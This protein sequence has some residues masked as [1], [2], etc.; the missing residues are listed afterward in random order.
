LTTLYVVATPI[1][2]LGD[3]SQR[4]IETLKQVRRVL[5]EDT[6]RT[7]GL[8]SHL[9]ISGKP[10]QRLDAHATPAE[11]EAVARAIAGGESAA[12]VTDAGAPGVSDPG[13]G[14]MRAALAAGVKLVPIPGPSAVTTAISLCDFVEGPFAFLGFLP[15]QGAK[16]RPFIERIV[17]APEPVVLFESPERIA[18]TLAELAALLP[19][20]QALVCRELTKLHE[21]TLRGS[22]AELAAL[23][24]EWLGEITLVIDGAS[25]AELAPEPPSDEA[26]DAEIRQRLLAGEG[27]RAVA[28][29][30][31]HRLDRPR[32]ELY[33]RVLALKR[34]S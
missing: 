10:L 4:A 29:A 23:E 20:R 31:A 18:P 15:R 30:L 5:A 2:N 32:R 19:E 1:G 28:D 3:L 13:A 6:R 22:V 17:R 24:R 25:A 16:R 34:G 11:L 8:L 9:G 21:E 14:L 27:T 33:D 26:I 7:R 12:L